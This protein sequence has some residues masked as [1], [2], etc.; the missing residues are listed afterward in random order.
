MMVTITL[1]R[2]YIDHSIVTLYCIIVCYTVL[3]SVI[4]H[5]CARTYIQYHFSLLFLNLLQY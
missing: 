3:T 2:P 1:S 4:T 5:T